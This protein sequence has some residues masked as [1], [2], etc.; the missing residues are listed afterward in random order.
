MQTKLQQSK[1]EEASM[2]LRG[3]WTRRNM[4]IFEGKF[5]SPRKVL[6]AAMTC[7]KNFQCA[8]AELNQMMGP[9]VQKRKDTRWKPPDEGASKVNFDAAIDMNNY[10]LGLGIVARNHVGEVLFTLSSSKLFSGN[11]DTAEAAAL[12]RAMELVL[13]LDVK[14]VVFEGDADRVIKG[15][16]DVRGNYD[17]MEQQYAN[18]RGR[19]LL[20]PDWSVSFIHREGNCVAHALAKR[21]LRMEGEWCWIEEGPSE[22]TS[23][24]AREMPCSNEGN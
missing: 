20:R 18:I 4:M 3:L 2:I 8:R 21:A 10:K 24:I 23:I 17:W 22:I 5:E 19:F 6:T 11:F 13:E 7:L 15:V 1:L 16:T 12:W 14:N 9:N